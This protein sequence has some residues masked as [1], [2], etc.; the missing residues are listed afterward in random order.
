MSNF[1]AIDF[2]TANEY[3]ASACSIGVVQFN[4]TKISK[5]FESLIRPPKDMDNLRS[6]FYQIHGISRKSYIKSEYFPLVWEKLTEEINFSD[7]LVFAHNA[8]FDLNVLKELF[9]Y[10]KINFPTITYLCTVNLAKLTWNTYDYKLSTLSSHL[11]IELN[12][13]DALSDA[14]ACAKIAMSC[15]KTHGSSNFNQIIRNSRF[16]YGKLS[17][18]VNTPMSKSNVKTHY[19][20]SGQANSYKLDD[21]TLSIIES[22]NRKESK[23]Q[24]TKASQY[25]KLNSRGY[26]EKCFLELPLSGDNCQYC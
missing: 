4:N 9:A 23:P 5:K 7:S 16:G 10:Y 12:H 22:E 24:K 25:L 26:C 19:A 18:S 11:K 20:K 2:E 6:D 21:K 3:K 13:H 17:K 15:L 14:S 8:G 1:I